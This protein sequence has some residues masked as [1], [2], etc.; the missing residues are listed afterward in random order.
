MKRVIQNILFC[1]C[2]SVCCLCDAEL[3]HKQVRGADSHTQ[4]QTSKQIKQQNSEINPAVKDMDR[5]EC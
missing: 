2:D 5:Y 4:A 3:D 1:K